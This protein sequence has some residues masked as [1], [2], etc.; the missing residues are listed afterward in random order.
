MGDITMAMKTLNLIKKRVKLF[1]KDGH[2]WVEAYSNGREQGFCL[3]NCDK[4]V[5]IAFS[6]NRNSDDL[7]VYVGKS[8]H[9]DGVGFD[10]Q[11]NVPNEGVYAN[12]KFFR[13]DQLDKAADF[14]SKTIGGLK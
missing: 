3:V 14:I 12:K 6:E 2:I 10:M 13:Y 11:G 1:S 5:K 9:F 7:V 8:S 4:E